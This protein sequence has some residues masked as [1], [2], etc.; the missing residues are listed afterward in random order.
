MS[1]GEEKSEYEA[2]QRAAYAL[3]ELDAT[4]KDIRLH[5]LAKR[6]LDERAREQ[7]RTAREQQRKAR[8]LAGHGPFDPVRA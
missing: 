8:N 3:K 5:T 1:S 7:K 2:V 6:E 4:S